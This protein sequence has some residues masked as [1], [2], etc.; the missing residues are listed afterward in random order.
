MNTTNEVELVSEIVGEDQYKITARAQFDSQAESVWPLL[1]NWERFIEVG[2]PG[3]TSDFR[4]LSGGPEVVPS[5]FQFDMA[6]ATLKEEIY[7]QQ[8]DLDQGRY[9]LHY[10]TLEPSLGIV[11]YDAAL[12]LQQLPGTGTSFEAVRDVRFEPG[13][14]PDMLA[15]VVKSE[16]QYLKE[17]FAA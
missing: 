11:D 2:L 16:T 8:V 13:A 15:D 10:R 9:L 5:T 17:F 3:M 4:W 12:V 14:S 1:M 7:E 6:G